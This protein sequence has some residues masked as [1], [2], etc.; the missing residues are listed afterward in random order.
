LLISFSVIYSEVG[1]SFKISH[2]ILH[3][4][5]EKLDLLNLETNDIKTQNKLKSR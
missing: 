1:I 4:I 3:L 2:K 5:R